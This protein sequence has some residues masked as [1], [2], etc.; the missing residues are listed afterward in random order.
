MHRARPPR[1][2]P[3][4]ALATGLARR[5]GLL[6]PTSAG[7]T[8]ANAAEASR[9]AQEA[10]QELTVIDEQVHEADDHRRRSRTRRKP[11]PQ[12]AA[13]AQAA[14][15]V[16]EPQLRAIAQ[17]GYTGKSQ[18][19]VA[20]F[21]TSDSA[22]ELVQQMTTLDMIAHHTNGVVAAAQAV[23]TQAQ[24]DADAAA[25]KAGL[26]QLEAQQAEVRRR[27]PTTR[28]LRPADGRRAGDRHRRTGRPRPADAVGGLPAPR[29]GPRGRRCRADR[30]RPGGRPLRRG[31]SGPDGFDC[32]GL[33]LYAYAR[34]VSPCRTPAG[35]SRRWASTSPVRTCSPATSSSSTRRSA[36]WAST[37]ATA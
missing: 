29:P 34:P 30:A 16:Y 20:A 36:T 24:A 10:A 17:S 28:P 7:A 9:L 23:A 15:S 5:R 3:R 2:R 22:D 11:R 27:S 12:G 37:S 21:L 13:A 1:R 25:A 4:A 18:S 14:L 32:S 26:D 35:R 19:R 31:A 33:T 6:P 8:P